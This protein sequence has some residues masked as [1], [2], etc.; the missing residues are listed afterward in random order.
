MDKELLQRMVEERMV[1]VQKHPDADLFIYNYSAR[2]QYDRVWNE[3]TLAARGLILDAQMNYVARPF[4]KFFN[5][6]EVENSLPSE[7]FEVF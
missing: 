2:V 5:L 4:R 1:N 7:A 3:A 6:Q